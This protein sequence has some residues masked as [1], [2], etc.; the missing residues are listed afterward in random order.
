MTRKAAELGLRLK[1]YMLVGVP[2][3]REDGIRATQKLVAEVKK[4]GASLYLSVDTLVPKP[5]T[6]L[7]CHPMA[8]LDYLKRA[9]EEMR[10]APHGEFSYYDPMLAVAQAAIALGGREA[11]RLIEEAA[12]SNSPRA[13]WRKM[14]RVGE[15]D[16]VFK[17]REE[18]LPWSHVHGF[19]TP[20]QLRKI[21]E[22]FL[23][24]ACG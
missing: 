7:Q 3:E 15:L 20:S 8:P 14:L 5:Q 19:Y 21:Y 2:C 23:E 17:P 12:L 13:Y 9:I 4:T 6:P 16:Y 11:A 1:L 10:R 22:A 24:A 18:P